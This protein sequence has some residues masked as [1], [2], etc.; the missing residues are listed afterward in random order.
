MRTNRKKVSCINKAYELLALRAHS[1]HEISE[2]LKIRDYDS[3]EIKDAIERLKELGYLDDAKFSKEY[4]SA[5]VERMRLGPKRIMIDLKRKG[6]AEELIAETIYDIFGEDEGEMNTAMLAA[7][8]KFRMLKK[9]VDKD[10]MKR[11]LFDHLIRRG[12]SADIA[13]RVTF[14]NLDEVMD[15]QIQ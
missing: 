5:R 2:K 7:K 11:K 10:T 12:F 9:D 4:A 15:E 14:D 6:F 8:K 3:S 13:R 1:I